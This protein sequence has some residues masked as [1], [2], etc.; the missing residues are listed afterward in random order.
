[1]SVSILKLH[2]TLKIFVQISTDIWLFCLIFIFE[3]QTGS[4]SVYRLLRFR[5]CN[6][7]FRCN[8]SKIYF[9]EISFLVMSQEL[10]SGISFKF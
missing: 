2:Q 1:M 4:H 7:I 8:L 3:Y 9:Y 5:I 6:V 10:L